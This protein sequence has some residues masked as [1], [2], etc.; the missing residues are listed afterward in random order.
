[1]ARVN[2]DAAGNGEGQPQGDRVRRIATGLFVAVLLV[3]AVLLIR[4]A[5]SPEVFLQR[6]DWLRA[7]VDAHM[8][9]ALAVYALIFAAGVSLS[10]PG[11]AMMTMLG[12]LLFGWMIGAAAAAVAATA[13]ACVVFL[14]AR[15][16]LG[17][18]LAAR[19]GPR[20]ERI[21]AGLRR[22]AANYMLFLRFVPLFPFF[23]VNIAPALVGV[24][25]RTFLLTT[26]VGILPATFTMAIAGAG[27][28]S[29]VR[30]QKSVHEA[31]LATGQGDCHFELTLQS[32]FTPEILAAFGALGALALLPVVVRR[33][34]AAKR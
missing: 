10:M 13:G 11:A 14:I 17:T 27:L 21:S 12:G 33:F 31:C 15:T 9:R 19:G 29:A 2:Q 1:M 23:L 18:W 5:L 34:R 24:P 32:I 28:D 3:V 8:P 6:Y 4:G 22:D 16:T 26:A 20:L 7:Q 30:A 25:L